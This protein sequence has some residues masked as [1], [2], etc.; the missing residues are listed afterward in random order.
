MKGELKEGAR[1]RWGHIRGTLIKVR[2]AELW[3]TKEEEGR[4]SSRRSKKVMK[5]CWDI[6]WPLPTDG[7]INSA[8]SSCYPKAIVSI[9]LFFVFIAL[10][11]EWWDRANFKL[12][13]WGQREHYEQW[14]A[15]MHVNSVS[16]L[17]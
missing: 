7:E 8:Q 11:W 3:I 1:N 16:D 5:E 13:G 4:T 2:F 14:V 17:N 12:G 15:F 6:S 10:S 9:C